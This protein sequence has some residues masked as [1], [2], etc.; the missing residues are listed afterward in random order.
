M[1]HFKQITEAECLRASLLITRVGGA[2]RRED[3][4]LTLAVGEQG[5]S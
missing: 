1:L 5:D 2:E 3:V 4:H